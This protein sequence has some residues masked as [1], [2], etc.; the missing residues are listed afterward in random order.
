MRPVFKNIIKFFLF[1]GVSAFLFWLVFRDQD[2]GELLKVLREDVDYTWVAVAVVMGIASHMSRAMRWQLLTASMGYRIRFWNSFMGVMIGY[3]AN[4]AIPRM[5]EFTRCGV[6]S[7]YENVP[8]SKLLG[9]VVT[10]RVIDLIILL[11]LTV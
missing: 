8:F 1:L 6:V 11:S 5:G 3:F 4:L 7:K 9:T 10:E 2:W